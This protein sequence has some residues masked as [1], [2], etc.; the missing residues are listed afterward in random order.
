MENNTLTHENLLC[1][2]QVLEHSLCY[3]RWLAPDIRP[4]CAMSQAAVHA[5]ISELYDLTSECLHMQHRMNAADKKVYYSLE[6][7][8][9]ANRRE[10]IAFIRLLIIYDDLEE[11]SSYRSVTGRERAIIRLLEQVQAQLIGAEYLC[12]SGD[13]VLSTGDYGFA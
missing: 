2:F 11:L 7:D 8:T 9:C 4:L 10:L 1:R 12:R 13:Q 6:P 3:W 5:L